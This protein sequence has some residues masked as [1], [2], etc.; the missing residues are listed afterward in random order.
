[1]SFKEDGKKE[2]TKILKDYILQEKEGSPQ[3]PCEHLGKKLAVFAAPEHWKDWEN[4]LPSITSAQQE[5][6]VLMGDR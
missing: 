5:V 1:M 4:V 2:I 3:L 6:R